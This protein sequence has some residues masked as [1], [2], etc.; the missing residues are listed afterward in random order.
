MF[1]DSIKE[2]SV[3]VDDVSSIDAASGHLEGNIFSS[4][5]GE[6]PEDHPQLYSVHRFLMVFWF[7]VMD[8][9]PHNG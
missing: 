6:N 9:L 7:I 4:S 3:V 8:F 1:T 5:P 2:V